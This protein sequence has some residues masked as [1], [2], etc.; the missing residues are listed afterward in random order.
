MLLRYAVFD[1][2]VG[3]VTIVGTEKG[4]TNLLFGSFDPAGAVNEETLPIYDAIMEINQFFYGQR[5][6]FDIRLKAVATNEEEFKVWQACM[7]IPYGETRTFDTVAKEVGISVDMLQRYL[8]R[9]PLPLF[10][11]SHRITG[12][13]GGLSNY[14]GG[15]EI[16][17]KILLLESRV[18]QGIYQAG[19]LE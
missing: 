3:D 7:N 13:S 2:L 19:N 16:Q 4:L 12:P 11:P 18:T 17:S 9:N 5:K 10:I 15:I 14:V 6:K 8:E 1:T